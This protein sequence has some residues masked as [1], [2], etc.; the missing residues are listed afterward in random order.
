MEALPYLLKVN[1]CWVVF[2]GCYWLLF[3]KHTFFM[4]NRAYLLFSLIV[5]F[6]IPALELQQ[7]VSVV[8]S[9]GAAVIATGTVIVGEVTPNTNYTAYLL[10]A[11]Y[12]AGAI[13]MAIALIK[14]ILQVCQIVRS[15]ISVPMQEYQ[16]VISQRQ[17]ARSGSFSFLKWMII[18]N[19][20]YEQNFEPIFTH[21]MVHIRQWHT[22][23]ILLIEILKVLF[24][25][26]PA[27]WLYKRALQDTHEF[28][29]DEQATDRDN[30]ATFLLT[31]AKGAISSSVTNQFFNASLLKRR[32]HMIYRNRTA[33]WLRGKYLLLLPVLALAVVLMAARKYVSEERNTETKN[34]YGTGLISVKG[35][36]TDESGLPVTN[37]AI[38][39]SGTYESTVTN[40]TGNFEV[41]N[42]PRG[43]TITVIHDD[44]LR[45]TQKIR[46]PNAEYHIR[47]KSN[48]KQL[49]TKQERSAAKRML[50]GNESSRIPLDRWPGLPGRSNFI[51]MTL[52]YPEQAILDG[53]E[54]HV[55]VSFHIDT[56]GIVSDAKI[57]KGVRKDLD[58]EALRIV[59]MMPRWRPAEKNFKPVAVRYTMNIAFNIAVDTLPLAVRQTAPPGFWGN[60]SI[61]SPAKTGPIG[62][63]L[64]RELFEKSVLDLRD[65]TPPTT[66]LQRFR[67]AMYRPLPGKMVDMRIKLPKK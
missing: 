35:I 41:N 67:I 51:A 8:E 10:L 47:L 31:Y 21:E 17:Y 22:L 12:C 50:A 49:L 59:R 61:Y 64:V 48:A 29:A 16:L 54:G 39:F 15:G 23:D 14:A 66:K 53:V 32:I 28:L 30:Y 60:R 34:K 63:K 3:R 6:I 7:T 38:T 26:N 43:S 27:L 13:S 18:S 2:Y 36:V 62:D 4:L 24:W 58:N 40:T 46:K 57:E 5:S 37:A 52:K 55:S 11:C 25:F 1:I 9:A 20:D 19:D 42:I 65:S 44:F 56:A 33:A 45:Y